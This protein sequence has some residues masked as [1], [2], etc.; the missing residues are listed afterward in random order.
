MSASRTRGLVVM[1]SPLQGEARWFDPGRVHLSFSSCVSCQIIIT[2]TRLNYISIEC[3][4]YSYQILDDT[5]TITVGSPENSSFILRDP[6]VWII[7]RFLR[8]RWR[9]YCLGGSFGP[10]SRLSV[11]PSCRHK[12]LCFFVHQVQRISH[13]NGVVPVYLY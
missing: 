10:H 2:D 7:L 5:S 6:T 8:Q 3:F 4:K 11:S 12:R 9:F 13:K 1:T